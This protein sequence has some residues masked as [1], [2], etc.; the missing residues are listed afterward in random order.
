MSEKFPTSAVSHAELD[1][2]LYGVDITEAS[3]LNMRAEAAV[4]DRGRKEI[5]RASYEKQ[6]Q[7]RTTQELAAGAIRAFQATQ[8]DAFHTAQAE[9]H[10]QV[11]TEEGAM[12]AYQAREAGH[13]MDPS[14][15]FRQ[16]QQEYAL[17]E[18]NLASIGKVDTL[19]AAFAHEIEKVTDDEG[20]I[21]V[22]KLN[23]NDLIRYR[24]SIDWQLG[25]DAE[26]YDKRMQAVFHTPNYIETV[27]K[28]LE[29]NDIA[30][31]QRIEA[32]NPGQNPLA[33]ALAEYFDSL[34][35]EVEQAA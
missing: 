24:A 10:E 16:K 6:R 14:L 8:Y 25:E 28:I 5:Y 33:A 17:A 9:A 34:N 29:P 11:A 26:D 35:K 19:N 7:E 22:D 31:L 13:N 32:R 20:V 3:V 1:K 27:A 21:D 4:A 2:D 12:R 15:Y 18:E 23:K 30:T